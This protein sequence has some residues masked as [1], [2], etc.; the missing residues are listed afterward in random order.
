MQ[1]PH[2]PLVRPGS[3]DRVGDRRDREGPRPALPEES[4]DP[5]FAI[6]FRAEAPLD[7]VFQ[8]AGRR[9]R[10]GKL[11]AP[12]KVIFFGPPD[13]APPPGLDRS[14]CGVARVVLA[15]PG[16]DPDH[17]PAVRQFFEL[18]SGA[19]VDP[20]RQGIQRLRTRL[21]S[22]AAADRFR[23]IDED[24]CDVIADCPKPD[25]PKVDRLVQQLQGGERRLGARSIE[26]AMPG[27]GGWPRGD[28]DAV[29]GISLPDPE[30]IV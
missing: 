4:A 13:D 20:D 21:D 23:M 25:A 3:D 1:V 14:G 5:D 6:V 30:S 12:G 26:Q 17:P 24:T 28:C 11:S 10:E 15:R 27:V 22:P 29:Q 2:R 7:T 18:R 16:F 8:A 19:A 9:N